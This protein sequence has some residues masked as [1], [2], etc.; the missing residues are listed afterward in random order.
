VIPRVSAALAQFIAPIATS[1]KQSVPTQQG[2][3]RFGGDA[4]QS[5]QQTPTP[6]PP[7]PQSEPEIARVIPFPQ[8]PSTSAGAAPGKG[9]IPVGIS[10]TLL[11]LMN[12]LHGQRTTLLR[13][14]GQGMYQA[15]ARQQK[16]N[17]RIRKGTVLDEK[18]E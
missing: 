3:Q 18:A 16:K 15:A 1:G 5:K 6:P 10:Q 8:Q 13:W 12:L 7:S 9:A 14:L 4:K 2:F 17:G 11:Q